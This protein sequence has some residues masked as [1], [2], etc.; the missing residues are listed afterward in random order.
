MADFTDKLLKKLEL[1]LSER[2]SP[3]G[4]D[5]YRCVLS[6]PPLDM[7]DRLLHRIKD[8]G[9]LQ[10]ASS[11]ELIRPVLLP[12]NNSEDPTSLIQSGR[13]SDSHL[14]KVRTSNR[15]QF[16]ILLPPGHPLSD[17]LDTTFQYVGVPVEGTRPLYE[18][19]LYSELLQDAV[20][21]KL[22]GSSAPYIKLARGII[23]RELAPIDAESSDRREQWDLLQ[24]LH[25]S[26]LDG[27]TPHEMIISQLG[28]ISC[29][30]GELELKTHKKLLESLG[31][32]LVSEGINAG[33]ETL[34]GRADSELHEALEKCCQHLK[35]S[36]RTGSDFLARPTSSYRPCDT[37][38][39]PEWW[40]KLT[41]KVWQD[42][43][44]EVDPPPPE[45]LIKVEL[46]NHLLKAG[47]GYPNLIQSNAI[48]KIGLLHDY[49]PVAITVSRR[50]GRKS[51]EQIQRH[52][53]TSN[54]VFIEDIPPS[55]NNNVEYIFSGN[56]ANG[57]EIKPV[58]IKLIA[59]DSY[60]PGVFVHC[61]NANNTTPFKLQKKRGKSQESTYECQIG[62]SGTGYHQLDIYSAKNL[63]I[64]EKLIGHEV[65][66]EGGKDAKTWINES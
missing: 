54:G 58:K 56:N 7:L 2:I 37:G 28:L 8:R 19:E 59:L 53:L 36:C 23:G 46:Q 25:D 57:H 3:S 35:N 26:Q 62:L 5:S 16:L 44:E 34:K 45:G 64:S 65:T 12:D 63:E 18:T 4:Q 48:F 13:C 41:L 32:L 52:L 33:F 6:G 66:P 47:K 20:T 10:I 60:D 17:T 31:N 21:S 30:E 38:N 49:E 15:E 40:R 14:A 22:A 42:L 9:G 24:R 55:H 61:R 43:L 50:V 27:C 1:T 11:E 39:V 29:N 51:P